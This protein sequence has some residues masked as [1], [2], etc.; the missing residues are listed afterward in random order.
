MNHLEEAKM[1]M[2]NA[3]EIT[4]EAVKFAVGHALIAGVEQNETIA[5]HLSAIAEQLEKM[6]G[7]IAMGSDEQWDY[8]KEKREDK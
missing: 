6:N 8:Y 3:D 1:H 5:K 4:V 2:E 7:V